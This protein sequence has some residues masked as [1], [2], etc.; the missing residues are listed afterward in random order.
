MNL[1]T[2]VHEQQRIMYE[3][4]SCSIPHRIV[5]LSQPHI[6]PIPRGKARAKTEFGAKLHISL[7][8]GYARM[9]R[10]SFDAYNEAE[11]FLAVVERYRQ[12][13][14]HYPSRILAD[15]SY[16]NRE[17]LAFCTEHS[18]RLTG[19]ALGR[20]SKNKQLTRAQKRQEYDDICDRN[21]VEGAF[22]T[23][24]TAYGLGRIFARL[25]ETSRCVIGI[26]LL[27]MNLCKR[28][29]DLLSLFL[30]YWFSHDV[31]LCVLLTIF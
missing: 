19:P 6:R 17:T 30:T 10:L 13:Y 1:I 27:T 18:I 4:N 7:V 28:L 11:D 2:T 31:G 8:D 29:R 21:A 25:E 24:K 5:S 15:R 23:A 22:G 16:R 26:V 14:G 12:T 20:P 9:E 3:T